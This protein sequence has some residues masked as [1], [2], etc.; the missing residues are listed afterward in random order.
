MKVVAIS[1]GVDFTMLDALTNSQL[2]A[3]KIYNK[4]EQYALLLDVE[5]YTR[6]RVVV[7]N[8]NGTTNVEVA[9]RIAAITQV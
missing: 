3:Q 6:L 5:A 4:G 7:N 8:N 9:S 2:A 1:G